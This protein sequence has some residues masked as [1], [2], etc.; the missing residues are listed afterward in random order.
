MH[1]R[2][3]FKRWEG[4]L[5]RYSPSG[6][7]YGRIKRGG[8]ETKRARCERPIGLWSSAECGIFR[9]DPQQID[10]S[11]GNLTLLRSLLE[12]AV[13]WQGEP[14]DRKKCTEQ[15]VHRL[16]LLKTGAGSDY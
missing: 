4:A 6:V 13:R 10:P 14:R 12:R 11:R 15:E 1:S 8:K 2:G 3:H 9:D 7:Y 5:Y 16:N